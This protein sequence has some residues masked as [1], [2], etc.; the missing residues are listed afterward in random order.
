MI[1]YLLL[2]FW[3]RFITDNIK[4]VPRET[5]NLLCKKGDLYTLYYFVAEN[6]CRCSFSGGEEPSLILE[7]GDNNRKVLEATCFFTISGTDIKALFKTAFNIIDAD[8]VTALFHTVCNS[9]DA[10]ISAVNADIV[11]PDKTIKLSCPLY[12][13]NGSH[14]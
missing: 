12:R 4:K 14:T 10:F 7:T 2:L 13:L 3:K 6:G 9:A 8:I 1:E 5:Q 11:K